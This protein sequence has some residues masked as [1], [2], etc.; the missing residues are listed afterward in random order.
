MNSPKWLRRRARRLIEIGSGRLSFDVAIFT[1][2]QLLADQ[3]FGSGGMVHSSGELGV[4]RLIN[5]DKPCC[6]MW[7]LTSASIQVSER[8]VFRF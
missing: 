7:V 2:K 8:P 4:F 3:G 1:A 6:S 5:S